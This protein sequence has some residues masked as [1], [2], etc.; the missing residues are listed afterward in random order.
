MSIADPEAAIL[1]AKH[2]LWRRGS[3][4]WKLHQTQRK[5]YDA[6]RGRRRFFALCSRRL[7]KSYWLVIEAFEYALK[8]PNARISYAAPT[9]KDATQIAG[10][11]ALEILEDCPDDVKPAFS[12][13]D[14]EF[15]FHNGAVIRFSGVNAEHRE[16][17]RGRKAHVFIL[18]EAGT[19]D[20]LRYTLNSIVG[21]MTATTR[22]RILIASTP[23]RSPGHDMT[24]VAKDMQKRGELAQFTMLDAPHIDA[25]EKFEMLERCGEN[26]ERIPDILAGKSEPES[27]TALREYFCKLDITDSETA[28]VPEFNQKAQEEIVRVHERPPYFDAYVSIDPGFADST[29]ILFAY[30]DF[31]AQ[32]LVIEGE[33]LLKR[34]STD[35]IAQAIKTQE[36][37]LWGDKPPLLRISD[38][39]LRLIAD[40]YRNHGLVFRQANRQDSLGAIDLVRTM[41]RRRELIIAPGCTRVIRQLR[42]ATWNRK[43]SDFERTQE[44]AHFDLLA[45][46]KYLCREVNRGKNP[47]PSWY[48]APG[49]GTNSGLGGKPKPKTVFSDTPLGR[50][51]AKKWG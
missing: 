49:F 11:L 25:Q 31:A 46:L 48:H 1:A 5:L 44:D 7:G 28:V 38:I 36:E 35:D 50:K 30:W 27:T 4:V 14:K 6:A 34:A 2:E 9:M 29:G 8:N 24:S 19:M 18:D 12:V 26:P 32:K 17:L 37:E 47:Y 43:A 20:E 42:N 51:L 22:G 16:N 15:R 23:P 45:A 41:V 40:L 21:P 13:P 39:D 33:A 3:L 10:D